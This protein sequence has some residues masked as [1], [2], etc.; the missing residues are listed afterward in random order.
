MK[1]KHEG[2]TYDLALWE[3]SNFRY[4]KVS[5][6]V[7]L[8]GNRPVCDVRRGKGFWRFFGGWLMLG[9]YDVECKNC[10][11]KFNGGLPVLVSDPE[12][13]VNSSPGI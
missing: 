9:R 6:I 4:G 12:P 2:H 13:N 5:H 8:D 3:S 1:F 10:Y 7:D 11:R